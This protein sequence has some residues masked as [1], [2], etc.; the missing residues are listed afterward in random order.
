MK[1][2]PPAIRKMR[3]IERV[4]IDNVTSLEDFDKML[5]DPQ[6]N[7]YLKIK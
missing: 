4:L 2:M 5:D 6:F 3:T 7:L 1:K